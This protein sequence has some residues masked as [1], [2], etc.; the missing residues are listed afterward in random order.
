MNRKIKPLIRAFVICVAFGAQSS[1]MAEAVEFHSSFEHTEIQGGQLGNHIYTVGG[2]FGNVTCEVVR[3]NATI[4][5]KTTS[6]VTT[7]PTEEG[8]KESAFGTTV[9]K[10]CISCEYILTA[11]GTMHFLGE[12]IEHLG[13]GCTVVIKGPQ[14]FTGANTYE[15]K[16]GGHIVVRTDITNKIVSTTSGGFFSC[17]V[18]NGEHKEGSLTG[19]TTV[20]GLDTTGSEAA[21]LSVS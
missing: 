21:T 2:G 9:T 3:F 20:S 5:A 12:T 8:C 10:T 16:A 7:T 13:T 18:S 19:E 11:N 17:G 14:T 15:N 1:S 6:E 4:A